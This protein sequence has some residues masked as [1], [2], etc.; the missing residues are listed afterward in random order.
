M[1]SLAQMVA[2]R[3]PHKRCII[4]KKT[5]TCRSENLSGYIRRYLDETK[6]KENRVSQDGTLG[7]NVSNRLAQ[8]VDYLTKEQTQGR[9]H[10]H[11]FLRE[12]IYRETGRHPHELGK[13]E[14]NQAITQVW[15]KL[16][17]AKGLTKT[18]HKLAFALDPEICAMMKLAGIPIDETLV[19]IVNQTLQ[20]YA[21]EFYPGQSLGYLSGIHH[22]KKH[23]HAHILLY[24]QT[25][26]GTPINVSHQSRRRLA[27][28][29]VVRIDYQGF[30][31]DT[32]EKLAKR[33]YV[34]KLRKPGMV[35]AKPL[36]QRVQ[37]KL[38]LQAALEM[39]ER[40]R[41][42]DGTL[43]DAGTFWRRVLETKR[44]L[45]VSAAK[46]GGQADN[47]ARLALR[48]A[49]EARLQ[50]FNQLKPE[51]AKPRLER[52]LV[53]REKIQREQKENNRN[54]LTQFADTQKSSPWKSMQEL[55]RECFRARR[56]ILKG[57]NMSWTTPAFSD[58][59]EGRWF[60]KRMEKNDDLGRVMQQVFREYGEDLAEA[61]HRDKIK[62]LRGPGW[63]V[64]RAAVERQLEVIN[65]IQEQL[66]KESEKR[67]AEDTARRKKEKETRARNR[68]MLELLAMEIIDYGSKLK[69]RTPLYLSQY[70]SWKA[71]G[72]QIP[73]AP[74]AQAPA[75]E[76]ATDLLS[77]Y[78]SD[79]ISRKRQVHPKVIEEAVQDI[80]REG[81][82]PLPRTIIEPSDWSKEKVKALTEGIINNLL[83][84]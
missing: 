68:A 43:N 72:T 2:S 13:D 21:A 5:S 59:S 65:R 3:D 26:Q 53:T 28:G 12:E 31:K 16:I 75:E 66:R 61:K 10:V 63:Q 1:P 24:P 20:S 51:D 44:N 48:S 47:S 25:S 40:N 15:K 76:K 9:V 4:F 38:L 55:R 58:N 57:Q 37:S 29:R 77:Q 73:V 74:P 39:V 79:P 45:E 78:V 23:I 7:Q 30:L 64:R 32:A 8:G 14:L 27:N 11:G 49:Y 80:R 46:A 6:K 56:M 42:A 84:I 60:L 18:A 34:E 83:D 41:P 70:E 69:E 54:F 19:D 33:V 67:V 81:P 82:A 22:D 50:H 17:Q 62:D 52:A 35:Q 36:Q 71:T